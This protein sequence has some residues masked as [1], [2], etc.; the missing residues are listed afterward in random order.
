MAEPGEFV[1][2]Q[3]IFSPPLPPYPHEALSKLVRGDAVFRVLAEPDG[4]TNILHRLVRLP[5]S[6][7]ATIDNA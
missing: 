4:S 1:E 6:N 7:A 2:P 5:Q 3:P